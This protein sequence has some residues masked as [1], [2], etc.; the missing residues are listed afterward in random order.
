MLH[1]SV[2]GFCFELKLRKSSDD[3]FWLPR[4]KIVDL[5][6]KIVLQHHWKLQRSHRTCT[7]K[8]HDN[9]LF[10]NYSAKSLEPP[11]T[12]TSLSWTPAYIKTIMCKCLQRETM[13]NEYLHYQEIQLTLKSEIKLRNHAC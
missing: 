2:T 13:D 12:L 1:S 9:R 11:P 8:V 6:K 7:A 10:G 5:R 3:L 4:R